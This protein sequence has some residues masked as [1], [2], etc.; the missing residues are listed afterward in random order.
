M[1]HCGK[2]ITLQLHCDAPTAVIMYSDYLHYFSQ[3]HQL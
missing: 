1:I 3:L 2:K